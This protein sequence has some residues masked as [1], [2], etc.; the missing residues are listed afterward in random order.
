MSR[1]LSGGATWMSSKSWRCRGGRRSI[2][3]RSRSVGD[4]PAGSCSM[5]ASR[6]SGPGAT[7]GSSKS[8]CR[9]TLPRRSR[10]TRRASRQAVVDSHACNDPGRRI[11][12]TRSKSRSQVVWQTSAASAG[13]APAA[14]AMRQTNGP[15]RRTTS[16]HI[17]PSP[18]LSARRV[19]PLNPPSLAR[20]PPL[21]SRGVLQAGRAAPVVRCV[22]P[23]PTRARAVIDGSLT[24]REAKI[25]GCDGNRQDFVNHD[26]AHDHPIAR[27]IRVCARCAFTCSVGVR[28][29]DSRIR[30][31]GTDVRA[32]GT[33]AHAEGNDQP[34]GRIAD[35]TLRCAPTRRLP[36]HA[37]LSSRPRQAL[38]LA[39]GARAPRSPSARG[40]PPPRVRALGSRSPA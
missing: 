24:H 19:A 22:A 16:S 38:L 28:G 15:Y 1:W 13:V 9:A 29:G 33:D 20:R 7:S 40:L 6:S 31:T 14:R 35:L 26:D 3:G 37:V 4:G 2:T 36:C 32:D 25:N 18:R 17:G 34:A 21:A 39:A 27:T 12:P 8:P 11:S 23:R 10:V 5:S 30:S